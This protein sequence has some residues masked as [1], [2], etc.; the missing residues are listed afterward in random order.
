MLFYFS[1]YQNTSYLLTADATV[2][3][4]EAIR[5]TVQPTDVLKVAHHGSKQS[6]SA[7]FL[8]AVKPKYAIISVGKENDYRKKKRNQNCRQHNKLADRLAS[9]GITRYGNRYRDTNTVL[10]ITFAVHVVFACF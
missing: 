5:N 7:L 2:E 1:V 8:M 10:P 4:E 6:N 9:L 3:V